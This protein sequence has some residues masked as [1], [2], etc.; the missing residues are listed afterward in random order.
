M[1]PQTLADAAGCI[2]QEP[3]PILLL[4]TCAVLD[5]VRAPMR[6]PA[7]NSGQALL[8]AAQALLHLGQGKPRLAWLVT[9]SLV[10]TEFQEHLDAVTAEVAMHLRRLDE[11]V[12]KAR[13]AWEQLFPGPGT[14]SLPSPVMFSQ[15]PLMTALRD[16]AS[17]IVASSLVLPEDEPCFKRARHRSIIGRAPAARGKESRNDCE[18]VEHYLELS[19]LL[20]QGG[21]VARR[22]LVSSNLKDY[23]LQGRDTDADLRAEFEAVDLLFA[24]EFCWAYSLLGL[25]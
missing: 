1:Q 4:D 15:S 16:L 21:V 3:A 5:I 13:A 25:Q 18:I 7:S 20:Q 12:S 17:T 11:D 6:A 9:T 19:R 10:V 2:A 24:G 22:A 23:R 14:G 8:E